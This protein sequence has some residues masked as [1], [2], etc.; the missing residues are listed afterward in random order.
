MVLRTADASV[1]AT[2]W[3]PTLSIVR[4]FAGDKGQCHEGAAQ[5]GTP[6]KHGSHL[7]T[8]TY[9]ILTFGFTYPRLLWDY[10]MVTS[11]VP[12]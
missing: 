11:E 7:M 1:I 10:T 5:E 2:L 3:P 8:P 4:Y 6:L 9:V 12:C